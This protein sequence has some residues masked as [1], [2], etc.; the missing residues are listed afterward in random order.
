MPTLKVLRDSGLT[1]QQ[2]TFVRHMG[3]GESPVR[4]AE[5]AGY[6]EGQIAHALLRNP[7]VLRAVHVETARVLVADGPTNFKVLRKIRDDE[8]APKG[9][10]ADV[11]IKL[12]RLAGHIEPTKTAE[13]HEKPLSEMSAEE[14]RRYVERSQREIDIMEGEL[15]ARATPVNAPLDAPTAP[16]GDANPLGYLD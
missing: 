6:S 15:A 8:T 4:A 2:A 16:P 7:N 10:R 3:A 13:T 1:D 5:M 14:L 9:V 11:A 12:G